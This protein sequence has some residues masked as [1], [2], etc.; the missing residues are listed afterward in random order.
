MSAK[1]ER[2]LAIDLAEVAVD[3][4]LDDGLLKDIPVVG[5]LVNLIRLSKSIPD[6]IFAAKVR[7]FLLRLGKVGDLK[8]EQ[9]LTNLNAD[10]TQR[11]KLSE[12]MVLALDQV[13]DLDKADYIAYV[14][15][16]YIEGVIDFATL[17]R[18]LHSIIA[19][20][21]ADLDDFVNFMLTE[22]KHP[23]YLPI[24]LRCL[25]SGAFAR[26][27]GATR[28]GQGDVPYATEMGS[29]FSEIVVTYRKRGA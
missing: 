10:R 4:V 5:S 23:L 29:K 3:A 6:R 15:M 19:A 27:S 9:F 25:T 24:H 17:R 12:V 18:F 28:T 26:D 2:E 7:A 22:A 11:I 16:A 13:D 1:P 21:T 8:K 14:F 20:F